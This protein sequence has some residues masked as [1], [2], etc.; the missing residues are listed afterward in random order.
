VYKTQ[1][2]LRGLIPMPIDY[3]LIWSTRHVKRKLIERNI[4]DRATFCYFFAIIAFDWLQ[5]SIG[6]SVP[7]LSLSPWALAGTWLS[8]ATTV[9]GLLYLFSCN[10]NRGEQFLPRYLP[11]SVTVGWKFA[12][13]SLVLAT[14]IDMTLGV[15]GRAVAGWANTGV[16]TV[17]NLTMFWRIGEHLRDL[18][19]AG[20]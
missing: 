19:R 11:L 3:R 17:L 6:S 14:V 7:A 13:A 10:G 2:P 4:S 1:K 9:G 16:L 8:F 15:Y 5:F 18:S 20:D 12:I